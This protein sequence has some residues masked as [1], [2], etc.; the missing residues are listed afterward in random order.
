V[1]PDRDDV[2]VKTRLPTLGPRG[3]GWVFGQGMLFV[4]IAVAAT[5]GPRWPVIARGWLLGG[6]ITVAVAGVALA[7]AGV[8][9]LGASLTA[10]P[11]PHD[12]AE[13]RTLGVYRLARH[14]IYGGLILAAI[15]G[16]LA[17]S[18]L[19]LLP[20]LGLALLFEGKRRIEEA[21]LIERYPGYETYMGY[22]PHRFVPWIL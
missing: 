21:W 20:S 2:E 7:V 1:H 9:G 6:G 5:L 3:E 11:K 10:L 12:S 22:V 15:G 4:L 14:P 16:S 8:R 19:A 17:T 18:P 13:L